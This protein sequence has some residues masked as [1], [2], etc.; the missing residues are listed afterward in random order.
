MRVLCQ[1]YSVNCR[2]RCFCISVMDCNRGQ[3]A[4][5]KTLNPKATLTSQLSVKERFWELYWGKWRETQKWIWHVH[6]RN[7]NSRLPHILWRLVSCIWMYL[8]RD[9]GYTDS[10]DVLNET[11]EVLSWGYRWWITYQLSGVSEDSFLADG[12][13]LYF[14]HTSVEHVRIEPRTAAT[15]FSAW[16]LVSLF[17]LLNLTQIWKMFM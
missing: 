6:N 15:I 4:F 7:G 9:T 5:S 8:R 2:T 13:L 12:F 10:C 16:P 17:H 11:R 1:I 14:I 3:R